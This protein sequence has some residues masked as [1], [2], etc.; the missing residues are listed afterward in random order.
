MLSLVILVILCGL[1]AAWNIGANDVA[2]AVGTS[3]GSGALSLKQ[4]V[5]IAAVFEFL[6]AF[7][8]GGEVSGTI[9]S[10]IVNFSGFPG[11][12]LDYVYG[13]TAA[14][15]ATGVWL[16]TASF[17]GWPVST[18]HSIIGAV[19]GFGLVVGNSGAIYWGHVFS[20]ILSWILSP[21]FGGVVSF[22]IFSLI[23]RRILYHANPVQAII[24]VAPYLAFAVIAVLTGII[25]N[26][27][28]LAERINIV[29]RYLIIAAGGLA[30]FG[31]TFLILKKNRDYDQILNDQK[32]IRRI[33]KTAHYGKNYL[34]VEV[35]FSYFQMVV[36]CFMAFAHGSNDVA[37]AIAPVAAV[38][39]IVYPKFMLHDGNVWLLIMGGIGIVLGLATWGWR[40]IETVGCKITELTPSRG[41]SAGF[42]SSVTVVLASKLGFP[43]STTHVV[44]GAILGVGFARGIKAI[45]LNVIR[46]IVF[47]WFI[48][49]PAGAGLS[50]LFFF[51]LRLLF[52]YV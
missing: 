18:T 44:V 39:K 25:L 50:I 6:G 14:L 12:T 46:D 15:L 30:A 5:I 19:I 20:I 49:V 45:N 48:T 38:L 41:F 33:Q 28:L 51:I 3:V 43:I 10:R 29:Y 31:F 37:N 4:A 8:F 35:I 27:G 52:G 17:F 34:V 32:L 2:N 16:Q 7:V 1:Y 23:R 24:Q 9:E 11:G 40:V 26:G 13:M 36:A 22:V 47:S 42:G 21:L